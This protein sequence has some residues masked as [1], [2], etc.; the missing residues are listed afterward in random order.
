[1]QHKADVSCALYW[2]GGWDGMGFIFVDRLFVS[3]IQNDVH[4][5]INDTLQ[6]RY[7][8]LGCFIHRYTAQNRKGDRRLQRLCV[9]VMMC[10]GHD[11]CRIV[12]SG[13]RLPTI[14]L[15]HNKNTYIISKITL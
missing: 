8:L 4:R 13:E 14:I 2:D 10:T 3:E 1:M 5:C 12:S 7:A 9:V 15:G 6:E 11:V